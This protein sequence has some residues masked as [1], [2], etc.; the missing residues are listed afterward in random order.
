M[1]IKAN[2]SKEGKT[3]IKLLIYMKLYKDS[4]LIS[5]KNNYLFIKN[6]LTEM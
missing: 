4:N 2:N 5:I 6:K 1:Y 3:S